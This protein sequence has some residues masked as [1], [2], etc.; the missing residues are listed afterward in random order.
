[1]GAMEAYRLMMAAGFRTALQGI[2]MHRPW[3]EIYDRPDVFA[4]EDWR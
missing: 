2:A 4:L 3:I 1:M